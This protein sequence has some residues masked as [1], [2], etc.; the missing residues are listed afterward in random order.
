MGTTRASACETVF[1]AMESAYD[2]L[3]GDVQEEMKGLADSIRG[4]IKTEADEIEEEVGTQLTQPT[5]TIKET[6]VPTFLA[7]VDV[8]DAAVKGVIATGEEMEK[9]V[10]NLLVCQQVCDVIKDVL[11]A[12]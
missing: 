11:A 12:L 2:E 9:T 4:S 10:D 1:G 7:Q 3:D 6:D 8:A 5:D